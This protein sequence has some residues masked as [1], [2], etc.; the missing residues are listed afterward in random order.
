MPRRVGAELTRCAEL[1]CGPFFGLN[2]PLPLSI[3]SPLRCSSSSLHPSAAALRRVL[4]LVGRRL[5]QAEGVGWMV[6]R[7]RAPNTLVLPPLLPYDS[8]GIDV[9][10]VGHA[11]THSLRR[12]TL[13]GSSSH[14]LVCSL[15]TS[16]AT[17]LCYLPMLPFYA[18]LLCSATTL[19][20]PLSWSF[21]A[22]VAV[23]TWRMAIRGGP[24]L[25]AHRLTG[26]VSV[27]F[28]VVPEAGTCGGM[29]CDH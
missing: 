26:E 16:Y 9:R 18:T 23:L 4:T 14:P 28:P 8:L 24:L 22:I 20:G 11:A 19:F 29:L 5:W 10:V 27:S 25:Y 1:C 17:F 3:P 13:A 6:G 12:C 21:H 7:E 2:P 15:S